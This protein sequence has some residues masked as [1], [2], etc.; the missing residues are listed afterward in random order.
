MNYIQYFKDIEIEDDQHLYTPPFQSEDYEKE[1]QIIRNIEHS[2]QEL[3]FIT[4]LDPA[5]DASYL[6]RLLI[7]KQP[8]VRNFLS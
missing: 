2:I 4:H 6:C 5:Q 3:G 8:L 1:M 7:Q